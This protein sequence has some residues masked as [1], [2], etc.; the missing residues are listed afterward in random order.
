MVLSLRNTVIGA[1]ALGVGAYFLLRKGSP[2]LDASLLAQSDASTTSAIIQAFK[3]NERFIALSKSEMNAILA[4]DKED[5]DKLAAGV[6]LAVDK[7]VLSAKP[8]VEPTTTIDVLGKSPE[9]VTNAILRKLPSSGCI[10]VLQGLSG[11]GKGTTVEC[12]KQKLPNAVTWSNGNVFRSLTLL[13]VTHCEQQGIP[14]SEK[15]LTPALLQQCVECLTFD[16]FNGSFDTRIRGFGLDVMVSEVQNTTLKDPKV[17]KNIPTVAKWTQGEVVKFAG[18]AAEKMRAEGMNVLVEGR[19]QTLNHVHPLP[20][21]ALPVGP[22]DHRRA[23]GGAAN[24]GRGAARTQGCRRADARGHSQRARE[25]ARWYGR[26][27]VREAPRVE[28]AGQGSRRRSTWQCS[29]QQQQRSR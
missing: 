6:Q 21:R 4:R 7:G 2:V 10:M 3:A 26:E 13:A 12:L 5:G 8:P 15:V 24:D 18:G 28:L 9:Q 1:G 22:D 20:L 11:T 25:G 16:K 19:E 17:G 14:F 29:W 27:G 23:A